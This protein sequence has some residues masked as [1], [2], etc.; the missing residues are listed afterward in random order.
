MDIE[1][2]GSD[3]D[4]YTAT[5]RN[6]RG[7]AF[8]K[9]VGGAWFASFYGDPKTRNPVI[10]HGYGTSRSCECPLVEIPTPCKTRQEAGELGINA[11][12][13]ERP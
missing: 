1:F 5:E 10:N 11:Y 4:G 8:V 13:A 6:M 3:K 9:K 2:T 12:N 7:S